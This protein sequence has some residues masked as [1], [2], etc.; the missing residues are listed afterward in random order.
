MRRRVEA[1][2]GEG[3]VMW[4][5]QALAEDAGAACPPLAGAVS[6]DVCVVGGGYTG[7][8]A[9]I[10]IRE[11]A[12]D[13]SVVLIEREG[14]GFGAS[15][16]NGGWAT[17]WHDELDVL[18][19][20]FGE[21]EGLRLASRSSWAIDRIESF[22]AEHGIAGV[23]RR[24]ALWTA[25]APSQLGSWDHAVAACERLGRSEYL[26]PMSGEALRARTGSPLLLG[27][28]R[29][30]DAAAVDPA[31]LARGLRRVAL[32][33]GVRIHEGTPMIALERPGC[34]RTPAGRI[35]A[36]RVILATGVYSGGIRELRRAFVPVASQIV[37]TAPVPDR[38]TGLEWAQGE[39]LGDSR[40]MVHY[41]QVSPEGRVVFGRGGGAIGP[42]GRVLP[43]HLHDRARLGAVVSDL[44][45]WFPA[46]ADVPIT[47][48]WGGA[49]DRAPGHL[50]FAGRLKDHPEVSYA[51]GYSGNGVAP[52]AYL[53][54][55]VA[56]MALDV[57]DEDT[58]SPLTS[59]PPSYLPPEPLR[60]AGGALVRAGVEWTEWAED[61]GAPV[62][63]SKPLRPLVSATVP[64]WLEP[65]LRGRR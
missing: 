14:C 1:I 31:R 41:A 64:R 17:G 3:V 25:A 6:A 8:W 60:S 4:L 37:A 16:R 2:P 56:R 18:V 58:R 26:E 30:T 34:V 43:A 11:Q 5:E 27:G 24:G 20:R 61:R 49:V 40:L 39:L 36:G 46:L 7:L 53:G 35:D 52:S 32:E 62:R 15:G 47:H 55:V 13:L 21:A 33:K 12:P 63:L 38:L 45:R 57:D 51:L 19:E 59:G 54:R 28:V 44:R 50:P 48:A 9:A 22:A 10:E 42:A 29:Q 23:R 65:R